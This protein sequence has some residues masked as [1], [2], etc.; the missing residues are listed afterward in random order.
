M[1]PKNYGQVIEMLLLM[2]RGLKFTMLL[3]L[4]KL[5]NM[6]FTNNQWPNLIK[7]F[8]GV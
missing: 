4:E 1:R 6:D 2:K 8:N 7:D 3:T 5:L